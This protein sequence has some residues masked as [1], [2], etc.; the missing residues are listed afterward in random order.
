MGLGYFR[1]VRLHGRLTPRRGAACA[2]LAALAFALFP[3]QAQAADNDSAEAQVAMLDPGSVANV[4]D[5]D[6]GQIAQSNT[7]GTVTLSPSGPATCTVTGGLIRTGLCEAA[8]FAIRGRRNNRVRIREMNGGVV[9]LNGPGGATMT[10]T[11]LTIGVSGM[12]AVNGANGW[13]FGNW[14]IDTQSGITEFH[15]GGRLNVGA[16]QTP[17][18]YN[19]A[20]VIQIQ[21]N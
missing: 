16:A 13:N 3:S 19:G 7:P 2:L 8:R 17:G 5:M 1:Q 6:F 10:V 14:R 9:T 20:V 18:V 15:L 12:T 21:F 11:N 4:Q